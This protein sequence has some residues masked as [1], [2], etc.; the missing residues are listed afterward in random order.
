MQSRPTEVPQTSFENSQSQEQH[1]RQYGFDRHDEQISQLLSRGE[2][3]VERHG[4]SPQA[5]LDLRTTGRSGTPETPSR[6]LSTER[7]PRTGSPAERITEYEQALTP[8]SKGQSHELGFR[9]IS[10]TRKACI[11]GLN[12]EDFPNGRPRLTTYCYSISY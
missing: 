12:L 7:S 2:G 3:G 5:V 9:V 10:K 8:L 6:R 1:Y 11:G 4:S